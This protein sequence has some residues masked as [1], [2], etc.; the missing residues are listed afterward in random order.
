MTDQHKI[1]TQQEWTQLVSLTPDQV[2]EL[3]LRKFE[4][5][6]HYARP[7]K[8]NMSPEIRVKHLTT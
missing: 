3:I 1:K 7:I 8:H 6:L 5:G 2:R 4:R